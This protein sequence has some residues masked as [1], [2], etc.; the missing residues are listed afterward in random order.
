MTERK[1]KMR[2]TSKWKNFYT[3]IEDYLFVAPALIMFTVFFIVPII[4]TFIL[5]FFKYNMIQPPE[6]IGFHNFIKLFNS[7]KQLSTFTNTF[8]FMLILVPMHCVLGLILAYGVQRINN[9]R[10]RNLYRG[11]IYFPSIVTTAS[12]AIA[13]TYMFSTDS[14]FINYY[15]RQLGF[16]NVRWLTD[17]TMAYVTLS[18][19]SFWKFIGT[20]FLYYFIGLNNIPTT[21]YEAATIDGASSFQVFRKITVPLLSPTIFFVMVTTTIGVFQIFDEPYFITNGGPGRSTTTVSLEIYRVAFQQLNYGKGA[22]LSLILFLMILLVTVLQFV[23][24]KKWVV[25]D[26][27]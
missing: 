10:L 1:E 15:L 18:I 25:Y 5:P 14:G 24:Q 7:Q 20:T 23:L 16:E 22:T 27:E 19:F 13:F 6:F 3:K 8:K 17:G 2:K 12:V 9:S 4:I 11:A 26:Y 21:Y